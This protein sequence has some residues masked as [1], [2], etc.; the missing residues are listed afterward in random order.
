MPDYVFAAYKQ[1]LGVLTKTYG[2]SFVDLDS[3]GKFNDDDFG[4]TVHLSTTGS[5][6][7]IRSIAESIVQYQLLET[8]KTDHKRLAEAGLKI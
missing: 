7:L 6:K 8:N 1:N 4:D 5:I 3:S 2:A